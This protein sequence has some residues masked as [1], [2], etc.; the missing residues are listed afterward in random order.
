MHVAVAADI[1]SPAI[2]RSDLRFHWKDPSSEAANDI[3][4]VIEY[5]FGAQPDNHSN[6]AGEGQLVEQAEEPLKTTSQRARHACAGPLRRTCPP[7]DS[8]HCI[9]THEIRHDGRKR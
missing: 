9:S 1:W 2:G 5:L 3:Q 4:I 8:L 7:L 6:H